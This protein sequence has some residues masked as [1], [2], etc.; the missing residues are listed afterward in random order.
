L[1]R[2]CREFAASRQTRGKL[3]RQT[4]IPVVVYVDV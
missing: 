1:P 4:P 2:V 3:S